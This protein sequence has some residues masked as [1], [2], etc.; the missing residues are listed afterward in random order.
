MTF[1]TFWK[2]TIEWKIH[3]TSK[4]DW[5]KLLILNFYKIKCN[6]NICKEY[7]NCDINS[8]KIEKVA[9]ELYKKGSFKLQLHFFSNLPKRKR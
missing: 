3:I 7:G 2:S 6:E 1:K 4:R 8:L 9:C 5:S